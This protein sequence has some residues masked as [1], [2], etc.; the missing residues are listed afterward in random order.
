MLLDFNLSEDTKLDG[1]APTDRVGGTLRYM[2]PEQFAAFQK[3]TFPGDDRS[4]L[5]S[6]G[7]ILHELLTGR[8]PN[9]QRFG[10]VANVLRSVGTERRRPLDVRRWNPAV[11]PGTESIVRHCLEPDPSRRYQTARELHDDLRRQST[12]LPLK[13]AVE[14][15]LGERACK[16]ARRHPRLSSFTGVATVSTLLL[17]VLAGAF[18]LRV[19]HLGR[20][21]LEQGAAQARSDAIAARYRLHDDLKTIEFLLGSDIPDSEHEQREEGIVL[22]RAALDRYG[23][24]GSLR[25]QASPLVT[26]LAHGQTEQVR[27]DM[28]ELLLLLAGAVAQRTEFEFALRLNDMA[29]SCYPT[30]GVP[31]AIRRQRA[32]LARSAGQADLAQRLMSDVEAASADSPRERYLLLLTQFRQR[33]RLPEALPWLKEASRSRKDNFSVWLMLGNCNAALGNRNEALKCYDMAGGL[34][35]E[36]HW[37]SM[38]RGLIYLEQ[39]NDRRALAS[40]NEVVR[41]RPDILQAYFN[42]ALAKY[43]LGDL[44][45]ARADLT[46][47]LSKPRPPLRAYFLR[48]RVRAKEGDRAGARRDQEEGMRGEPLDERDLTARGL[49]RQPRDPRGA[50]ADYVLAL[51]RNPRCRSAL[52]NKAN[53]LAEDLGRTE[54]AVVALDALLGVYPTYV[55]ALA[56]RGVL[57]ARLGHREAA[58]ADAREALPMDTKPFNAYQVAGIY[59]LTS[60]QNPD[61]RQEAL[62]LLE[63]VLSQGFGL[64]LLDRDRDLDAIRDQAEFRRLVAAARARRAKA[65]PRAMPPRATLERHGRAGNGENAI[66]PS[67]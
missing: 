13:Y 50:L 40:F 3:G 57:H 22:A 27:E 11:S 60:R 55:P 38:C 46:R 36:A 5:Y 12:H 41:L 25:W 54:E 49:I 24:L 58:H 28:G 44:A 21:R 1:G 20:L 53:V 16:W 37:P 56:G 59:A 66:V 15:S 7:I 23:V 64:D 63:S 17:F 35:P 62:H 39:G 6:F 47:L 67:G 9:V 2:A 19:G 48:A 51:E 52:Q 8:H 30:D 34:W 61:D 42:R 18:L 32:E 29:A 45:G 10:S 4:D 14:P 33:G 65:P 31:L 26:A 43:H